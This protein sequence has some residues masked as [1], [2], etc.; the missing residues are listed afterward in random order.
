MWR[1][2]LLGLGVGMGVASG[3][4]FQQ[5]VWAKPKDVPDYLMPYYLTT[6]R[7]RFNHYSTAVG[8]DGKRSMTSEDFVRAL[9]CAR[10]PNAEIPASVSRDLDGLFRLVDA[11]CDGLLSFT[12]FSLFMLFLTNSKKTFEVAFQMFDTN[13]SGTVDVE[14]FKEICSCISI[15]P[16]VKLDFRGGITQ[17]FFGADYSRQL[18]MDEFWN[19]VESLRREVWRAEFR[20]YDPND[21]G[22]I[23]PEFF[24][25]LV[26]DSML[27]SH[28]PFYI[29][30]NI[31]RLKN[32][33]GGVL[34]KGVSFH[35]WESFNKL[36][37]EAPAVGRA[38]QAYTRAGL[39]VGKDDFKRAIDIAIQDRTSADHKQEVDLIFSVFDRDGDGHLEFDEFLA[40]ARSK[41][42]FN[43]MHD[44]KKADVPPAA[45]LFSQCVNKAWQEVWE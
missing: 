6:L 21:T 31:R 39:P 28:V 5:A 37:L 27:G 19:F 16:T 10:M 23:K 32:K 1:R 45:A 29:V 25:K 36:M 43:S 18:S 8:G 9:L 35:T 44:K 3:Y 11:N 13:E 17:T 4:V 42:S 2:R 15:D 7:R 26:T 33:K 34:S 24:A 30:D 40:V 12:E 22:F 41:F 14:E 38:L 20:Q